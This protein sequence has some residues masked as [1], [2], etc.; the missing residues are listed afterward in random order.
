M[1]EAIHLAHHF[2]DPRYRCLARAKPLPPRRASPF[3]NEPSAFPFQRRARDRLSVMGQHQIGQRLQSVRNSFRYTA[4]WFTNTRCFDGENQLSDAIEISPTSRWTPP[5]RF[6]CAHFHARFHLAAMAQ[7]TIR[8]F[9]LI[10]SPLVDGLSRGLRRCAGACG[11]VFRRWCVRVA[12]VKA[13]DAAAFV[14]ATRGF[15]HDY[16]PRG[17]EHPRDLHPSVV[18]ERLTSGVVDKICG[19]LLAPSCA[20]SGRCIPGANR[21]ANFG[22]D[23]L[24]W[25]APRVSASGIFSRFL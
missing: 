13:R 20:F 10:N 16:R 7:L 3:S 25:P 8:A 2:T 5:D 15:V 24:A 21:R 4:A 1:N 17:A 11:H 22:K 23:A 9:G 18:C 14:V 6:K 19:L 12:P